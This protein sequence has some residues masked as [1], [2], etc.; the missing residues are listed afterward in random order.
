LV[1]GVVGASC[2]VLVAEG[3]L[4]LGRFRGS[5]GNAGTL[6]MGFGY[7]AAFI[8]AMRSPGFRAWAERLAPLGRMVLTSYLTQSLVCVTI[9]YGIG[10]GAMNHL[11]SALATLLA[12]AIFIA[13]AWVSSAW[14]RRWRFGPVEWMWRRLTYGHG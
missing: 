5:I 12:S 10:L 11:G 7:V 9:F 2:D 13:Q 8:G 4:D 6:L 14:L 1:V 3:R